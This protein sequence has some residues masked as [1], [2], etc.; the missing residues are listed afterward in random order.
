MFFQIW[1]TIQVI[2]AIITPFVVGY[3]I[4]IIDDDFNSFL[5]ITKDLPFAHS[6][7]YCGPDHPDGWFDFDEI[8]NYYDENFDIDIFKEKNIRQNIHK[9]L[10]LYR[11]FG[12]IERK[13][14][15]NHDIYRVR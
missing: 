8:Y 9:L 4:D 7:D 1:L 3:A 11:F 5:K 13:C 14:Y 2:G 10:N 12:I 15:N 6:Y